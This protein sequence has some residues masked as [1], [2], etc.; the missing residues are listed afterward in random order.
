MYGVSKRTMERRIAEFE[1][2]KDNPRYSNFT[3]EELDN[4]VRTILAEFPNSV[5]RNMKGHL[6]GIGVKVRWEDV[7]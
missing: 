3:K 7:R 5:I 4:K 1:I 2:L 6:R